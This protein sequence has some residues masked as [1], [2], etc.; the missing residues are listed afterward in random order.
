MK[1]VIVKS[2]KFLGFLLRAVFN[3]KK[4]Q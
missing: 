4:E 3:I 1:V 2:G